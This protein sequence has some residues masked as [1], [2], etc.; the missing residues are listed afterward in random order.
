MSK[1][2]TIF[3]FLL[4]VCYG[5]ANLKLSNYYIPNYNTK[6][7]I[8]A[9]FSPTNRFTCVEQCMSQHYGI[10]A[11]TNRKY[12]CT[13]TCGDRF[14]QDPT[15]EEVSS[16]DLN[17]GIVLLLVIGCYTFFCWCN[18]K[19]SSVFQYTFFINFLL[20]FY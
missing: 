1:L 7:I 9:D 5:S 4:L 16:N 11:K 10:V 20:I 2:F 12:A 17:I 19:W 13:S 18:Q 3:T 15:P 8:R 6:G 14:Y